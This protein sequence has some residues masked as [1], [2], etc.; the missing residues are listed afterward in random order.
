M[1]E[2]ESPGIRL[3]VVRGKPVDDFTYQPMPDIEAE[4]QTLLRSTPGAAAVTM[5]IRFDSGSIERF[6]A[7]RLQ[8]QVLTRQSR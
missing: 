2:I 6:T 4:L 1:A 5:T 7:I 3:A 8:E